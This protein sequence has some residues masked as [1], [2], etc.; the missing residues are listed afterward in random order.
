MNRI[1]GL[2]KSIVVLTVLFLTVL[3]LPVRTY[4]EVNLIKNPG[5]EEGEEEPSHW[6]SSG[7]TADLTFLW[8]NADCH[9]G[10]RSVM[11]KKES[12]NSGGSWYP[13]YDI[14]VQG[15]ET[16]CL[17]YWMKTENVEGNY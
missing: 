15:E 13:S 12:A 11:I 5:F 2:K 10:R 9:T 8:D 7:S 16:Y 14:P 1:M 3:W 4:S 17:T 6:K